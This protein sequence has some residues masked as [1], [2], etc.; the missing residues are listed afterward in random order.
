VQNNTTVSLL[1]ITHDE[2]GSALL[3][4]VTNTLGYLP[5]PTQVV[6]IDYKTDP[7]QLIPQLQKIVHD[8]TS[9]HSLLI[10]T[11]LFGSTPSN[12]AQA[13]QDFTHVRVVAGL[14][15]PMLIRV[16]NYPKLPLEALVEKALSGGKDGVCCCNKPQNDDFEDIH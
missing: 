2:I 10:L 11:D 1:L 16:M 7:E 13:L 6:S 8:V 4:A 14:N 12:I 3:N 9:Q 15:L 5:I